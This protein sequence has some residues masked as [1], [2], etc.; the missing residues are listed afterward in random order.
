MDERSRTTTDGRPLTRR[1]LVQAG[2][3]A[4]GGALVAPAWARGAR[5]QVTRGRT[6]A[7]FGGGM[8]GLTAAHELAE[9]G[10]QVTVYER[11]AL[12]G[13]ARSIPHPRTGTGGRKDLPGEHGFRFFP[14]FYHHVPDTMR[15]IPHHQGR[16]VGDR[17]VAASG[18]WF[19][20]ADGHADAG[21]L[22]IGYDPAGLFT[23]DGLRRTLTD[24]LGGTG[25]PPLE[26]ASFVGR[27]LVFLTSS[28]ERRLG[29][30]ER[31]SWW[32]FVRAAQRSPEY[33]RV[34]A[35]GLTR[36]L[37]AAKET[38]AS[39]R[40]IG[41]MGEAF[42]FNLL[43]QGNDGELD[44][45]LD[46]PTNEAWI[47]PW[48]HHLEDLGV[49]FHVGW[50]AEDIAMQGGRVRSVRVR[51]ARGRRRTVTADWYVL[52]TP[53]ERMRPLMNRQVLRADP[54][55]QGMDD[56]KTDWMVGIQYF[57]TRRPDFVHGHVSFLDAPWALTALTQAQFWGTRDI[58]R[59]Y[60]DG[61]VRDILSVDISNWDAPGVVFGKPAKRCDPTE[62]AVE[63]WEQIRRHETAGR[64]LD[65][66]WIKDW[67]LD[68][69]VVWNPRTGE[70]R[71][72][73]PLLVNTV[74]TWR[75]RPTARTRIPNLF[76]GGD[77]V[78]TNIDLATMEGANESGRAAAAG[79]LDAADSPRSA[80]RTWKLHAPPEL[81][82]LK[83]IDADR[84]R[85]GLPNLLDVG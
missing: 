61:T 37:V 41:T 31:V 42:V 83:R 9:R 82:G 65:K 34:L 15:R 17:L 22:G 73:T 47:D 25:V 63:T 5:R 40:T 85:A 1:R 72:V 7:V 30:W 53:V 81:E 24:L 27:L 54:S 68:P 43:G 45:V 8:A 26:L 84:F 21:P 19:L 28:P 55:L 20:R 49:R 50:A 71:N 64:R 35:A 70:N 59:D 11:N 51:G 33:Q 66:A 52:A 46:M 78:R 13:K 10:F 4:A 38:V 62:I 76:L 57:L 12:G 75:K 29:Q 74:D 79:I 69:G 58:A 18:G 14:G 32:E 36:N 56:L 67:M 2:A 16:T 60:G 44:R 48:V 6:V 80:P 3:A 77:H 39:T 23:V